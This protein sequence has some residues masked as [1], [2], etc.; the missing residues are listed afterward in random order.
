MAK[1]SVYYELVYKAITEHLRWWKEC[2]DLTPIEW[3][4]QVNPFFEGQMDIILRLNLLTT[5]DYMNLVARIR[6]EWGLEP[7]RDCDEGFLAV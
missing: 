4:L 5:D 7:R 1:K 3:Y 6:E 2:T